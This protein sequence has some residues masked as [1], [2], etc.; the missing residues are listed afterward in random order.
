MEAVLIVLAAAVLALVV[1]ML[2]KKQHER[3]V[4]GKREEAGELRQAARRHQLEAERKEM[5]AQQARA[6]AA[7]HHQLAE[8]VDPDADGD[9]QPDDGRRSFGTG[10]GRVIE[11]GPTDGRAA[12]PR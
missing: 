1:W 11:R 5:D 6:K 4:E 7:E 9:G 10:N 8:D 3:R 12:T 2:V